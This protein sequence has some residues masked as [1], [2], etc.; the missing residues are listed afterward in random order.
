MTRACA[1]GYTETVLRKAI[2]ALALAG[3]A[4]GLT[5][6][7]AVNTSLSNPLALA[8]DKS[9]KAGGVKMHLD[10]SFSAAGQSTTLSADGAFDGDQGQVT[11]HAGDL[12]GALGGSGGNGDIKVIVTKED[13]HPELYLNTGA[14]S[15]LIPGGKSW[16]KVD[17]EQAAKQFGGGQASGMLGATGQSPADVLKLLREVGTVTEVGPETIDG[18][19][20]THYRADVDIADALEKSGAPADAL[21]AVKASG[22]STTVPID[23]YIGAD[24]GYVHRVHIGYGSGQTVQGKSFDA[25]VTM[26]FSDWGSDVSVDVPSDDQVLD[27]TSLLGALGNKP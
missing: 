9:A 10:A 21:T 23:V 5:A 17:L 27:A 11:L 16:M 22:V 19:A 2:F 20:T 14:L 7:G 12:L 15:G 25:D 26:T 8:A 3:L 18:A 13:D 6:C 24:D 4:V 1:L